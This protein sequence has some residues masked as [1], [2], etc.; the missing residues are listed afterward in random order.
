[1]KNPGQKVQ[2][3]SGSTHVWKHI[4]KRNIKG[5]VLSYHGVQCLKC[6]EGVGGFVLKHVPYDLNYVFVAFSNNII[7][8]I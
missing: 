2:M 5:P 7:T 8:K 6:P 4:H 1:M 3:E